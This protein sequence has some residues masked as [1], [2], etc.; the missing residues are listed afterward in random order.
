LGISHHWA[1]RCYFGLWLLESLKRRDADH[2][3]VD[4]DKDSLRHHPAYQ[5][6]QNN[7]FAT[8]WTHIRK[9]SLRGKDNRWISNDSED[10][11][12]QSSH[13]SREVRSVFE[14]RIAWDGCT[15]GDT[16]SNQRS[17]FQSREPCRP[18]QT[19]R[20]NIVPAGTMTPL[21][22][23]LFTFCISVRAPFSVGKKRVLPVKTTR[24]A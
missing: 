23:L 2:A 21:H 5:R 4:R 16:H 7:P 22:V 8:T 12:S 17:T 18:R 10:M 6:L 20:G 24:D 11:W 15:P 13:S 14:H 19:H 3:G 9:H 1:P